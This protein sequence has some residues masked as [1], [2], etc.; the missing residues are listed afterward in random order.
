L[1]RLETLD[2]TTLAAAFAEQFDVAAFR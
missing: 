2:A 1:P